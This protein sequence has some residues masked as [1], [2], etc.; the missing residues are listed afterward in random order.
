[1]QKHPLFRVQI[2]KDLLWQTYLDSFPEGT[3]PVYKERTE[4]DC[5]CCK[6]FIR[7]VG[8]VVAIV[9]GRVVSIW[10][11]S[12]DEVAFNVV[13]GA[14]AQ[15]IKSQPIDN[16][17]L[18]TEKVAGTDKNF[19]QVIGAAPITW[20]HFFVNIPTANVARGDAIG[21]RLAEARS[22]RDVM[23]RG[24]TEI[25][26]DAIDTV[27]ELIAQSSIYRGEE[28]RPIV[29][30]FNKLRQE[31]TKAED[32]DLF[33]WDKVNGVSGA[34]GRIRNTVI[35]TLLTD[36]SEGK[37]LEHAVKSFETKV[38]PSN[39]KRPTALVTK[40]MI[41]SAR[42][43]IEEL[44]YL[45]AL[46][47]RHA[48][49]SDIT[50]NNVLFADRSA[51][52]LMVGS[53]FDTLVGSVAQNPK[54]FDKVEEVGIEKF[55]SDILPKA[56]S[57]ELMLENRLTGNLFN[58]IAPMDPTAKGMFKWPNN[59]SWGYNGEVADSELRKAVQARGGKVD[60]VFR[61]SH[62]WNYDARNASLMDLHVF[63]PGSNK[64]PGN[65]INDHYGNHGRVGWNA[66]QHT[67]SKGVQ[68][69]DYTAEAPAGYVPVE[70][71]TF[72]LLDHMPEGRYICKIHNWHL[73]QPTQ[74]GFRAEIEFGG[75]VFQYECPRPLKHKEWITVAEVFLKDGMFSIKHH[76]P[77]ASSSREIWGLPS[78][79]F[80][81]VNAVMNSPNH[82]DGH[83]VGNKH[84]MFVLDGCKNPEP[85]RGFFNEFLS[86]EL[87]AHRKV[88]EVLGSTLR[89]DPTD[90]QLCGIGFSS[91]QRNSVLCRVKGSFNR[92]VKI[93][94]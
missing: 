94:F 2:D 60:G 6:Q 24:L 92:V 80:H 30:E 73:R 54:Q 1:M 15:L 7:A 35:G 13:A 49:I 18:H 39:Y 71:I 53:V 65:E 86:N 74:G 48:S 23:F 90:S 70:N 31:F 16:I 56:D 50:I 45:S 9:E 55:L 47:R 5:T 34:V 77:T 76:L 41:E 91:T 84:Y 44:G 37:E 64:E 12:T 79:Q 28:H 89:V 11:V 68:D 62:S 43:K 57:I 85:A 25:T 42:R 82:W 88:L 66:R 10:D 59:F 40:S 78:Q 52:P 22:T 83:G 19:Q 69:V 38:A 21:P 51:K 93:S 63:M 29:I 72:P 81:K 20:E 75:E 3:N 46:Q 67:R 58:L 14:L 32:K 17:F 36:L 27:L 8:D 33:C 61:F 4:Y 87:D 26:D